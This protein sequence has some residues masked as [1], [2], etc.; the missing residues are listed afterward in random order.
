[1]QPGIFNLLF[2]AQISLNIILVVLIIP[3]QIFLIYQ[4]KLSNSVF[5]TAHFVLLNFGYF[6]NFWFT[7]SGVYD[8]LT[9]TS[10]EAPSMPVV[11]LIRWHFDSMMGI[12]VLFLAINICTA[13][14]FTQ[15]H[16][17]V[18]FK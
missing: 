16:K 7:I 3:L 12:W 9:S 10:T 13:L 6:L 2:Y 18:S 17:I 5:R 4:L 1:M 8:Q 11:L 15:T 14:A